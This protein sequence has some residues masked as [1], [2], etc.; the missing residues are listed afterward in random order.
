M[1]RNFMRFFPIICSLLLLGALIL[2][3]LTIVSAEENSTTI[4]PSGEYLENPIDSTML[5]ESPDAF[6][7]ETQKYITG[8][9]F[10]VNSAVENDESDLLIQYGKMFNAISTEYSRTHQQKIGDE[11]IAVPAGFIDDLFALG[12]YGN[13]C[14]LGQRGN[15]PIDALDYAC[16]RHDVCYAQMGRGFPTCDSQFVNAL[17]SIRNSSSWSTLSRW[18]QLYLIAAQAIFS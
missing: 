5:S 2:S 7:A 15:T 10:D 14:G 3:P 8:S 17:V 11:N 6:E 18:G 9:Y 13:Y 12:T 16:A 4:P 1:F